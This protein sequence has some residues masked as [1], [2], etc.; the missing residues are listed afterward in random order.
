MDIRGEQTPYD[1]SGLGSEI[2]YSAW[3][4][5]ETKWESYKLDGKTP[6]FKGTSSGLTIGY[7]KASPPGTLGK[8]GTCTLLLF[9]R[10]ES[11]NFEINAFSY[12]LFLKASARLAD[13]ERELFRI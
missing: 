5:T 1:L 13:T 3:I 9:P 4:A 12:L 6:I 2:S 10:K 11:D 8:F 7:S